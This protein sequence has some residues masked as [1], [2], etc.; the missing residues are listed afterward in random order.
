MKGTIMTAATLQKVLLFTFR[1]MLGWV[2]LYAGL[3]QVFL[4]DDW[5]AATFL[6]DAKTFTDLYAWFATPAI[7]P[8]ASFLVK[9]GHL[10]I[11]LSLVSG[12]LVRISSGFGALLMMLYYFPRM[13]FP[14]VGGV[15]Q[16]IVE[17]HLVYA[18]VLIYL[19]AVNAGRIWGL[20]GYLD[21]LPVIGSSLKRHP[22]PQPIFS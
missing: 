19:G 7:V 13:D 2:F 8:Y 20:E 15:N 14:Y 10:L 1:L 9:W 12:F 6:K 5:S 4:L 22:Q 11:G 17:Y 16:F 21:R 18:V 3:R